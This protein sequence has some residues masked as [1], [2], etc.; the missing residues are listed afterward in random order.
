[1]SKEA[2]EFESDGVILRG[3]FYPP[4]ESREPRPVVVMSHGWGATLR[5]GLEPYAERF[6]AA[7][8]GVLLFDN[9]CFGLSGG[10]PRNE[11]NPWVRARATRDAVTFVAERPDVDQERIALWGDSGDA[12]RVLLN[13]ACDERVMAVVA[14]N[15]TFG[16]EPKSDPPDPSKVDSIRR[17]LEAET[18]P[19]ELAVRDEGGP[20]VSPSPASDCLSPYPTSFRWFFE[21]GGRHGSGWQ[22]VWSYAMNATEAP[23]SPYDC[24]P[25]VTVPVLM[26]IGRDDEIPSCAHAVSS[27]AFELIAGPAQWH[28][29]DGGHFGALYEGSPAFEDAVN[30]EVRFLGEILGEHS[31]APR[32]RTAQ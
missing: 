30:A 19:N 10:A 14:F 6:S 4:N 1:M 7:G 15:P 9:P 16:V 21:Y 5:M 31:A 29:V 13:A 2:I 3:F 27:Q 24:L 23:F 20:I 25:R 17:T 26:V 18:L 32:S 11:I 12:A 22:N 28:D 8:L